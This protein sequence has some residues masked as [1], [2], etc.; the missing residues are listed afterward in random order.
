MRPKRNHKTER[1][2][3]SLKPLVRIGKQGVTQGII[4]EVDSQLERSEIVKVRILRAALGE[5]NMKEMRTHISQ[6]IME[7]TKSDLVEIRG[8]T[9][10]LHRKKKKT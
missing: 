9:I 10:I 5:D 4:E 2:L 7:R 3:N 8:N 6:E 1:R